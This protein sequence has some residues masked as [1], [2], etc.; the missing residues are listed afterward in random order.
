MA[1]IGIVS[2]GYMGS[3][4]GRALLDGGARVVTTL[5]GRSPRTARLAAG[6]GLEL[7]PT[8]TDVMSTAD[9]VLLVTPPAEAVRNARAVAVAIRKAGPAREPVVAD[10]NAVSPGTMAE[11]ARAL[12]GLPVVDGSIS[13]PPPTA[14]PGAHVYLSG[15]RAAEVAAL[16]WNGRV[17]PVVLGPEIGTASALKMCTASVLKG[18]NALITQAIRTAGRHGVLD[19]VLA[20]LTRNGFSGAAGVARSATKA[21]RYV[22]EMREIATTQ[23][24]AGLTPALF[25]AFAEVYADIATTPLAQGSPESTSDLPPSEI[26]ARLTVT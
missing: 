7:L 25:L 9:V 12:E 6:A 19:A 24:E 5:E 13:G 15:A 4:L 22:G 18:V 20:E 1:T 26:V 23:S 2:A 16:P 17:R 3:G 21:G 14:E 10:L 8:L 11:V